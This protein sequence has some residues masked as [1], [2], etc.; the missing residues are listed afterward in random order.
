MT[1]DRPRYAAYMLRL[2]QAGS[3]DG[4]TWCASLESPHT[5]ELHVFPH[6]QSLF[7]FLE[8]RTEDLADTAS[9]PRSE[10]S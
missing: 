1:E 2:W 10:L 4:P 5:G 8:K 9:T 7:A 3:D 6:L